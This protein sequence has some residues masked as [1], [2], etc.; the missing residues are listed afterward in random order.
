MFHTQRRLWKNLFAGALT[1][2]LLI[3]PALSAQTASDQD[4]AKK[5]EKFL[6]KY[7]F[8]LNS[9]GAGLHVFE[10]Y[11]KD[12]AFW[13]EYGFTSP[14]EMKPSPNSTEEFTFTDPDDGP[15]KITF[16][17]NAEGKYEKCQAANAALGVE[18]TG[19]K[20]KQ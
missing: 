13:V 3:L 12:S 18:F 20:I 9:V 5:Y 19:H 8:D 1:A 17:K 11:V 16:I 6:G 15:T 14:G 10:F 4:L 7:E 2:V